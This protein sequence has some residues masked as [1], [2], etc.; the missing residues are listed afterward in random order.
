M[1][2]ISE[3]TYLELCG[4]LEDLE[5]RSDRV[6]ARGGKNEEFWH[7]SELTSAVHAEL[8]WRDRERE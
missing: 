8:D 7:V 2:S 6:F 3:M 1:V 5:D 4:R